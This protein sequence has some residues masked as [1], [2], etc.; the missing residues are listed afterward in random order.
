MDGFLKKVKSWL[1]RVKHT[2]IL[3]SMAEDLVT[4][5]DLLTD[6]RK[7]IYR[8]LPKGVFLAAAMGLGYA[9]FPIDLILDIIPFAGYL[10]D[11]AILM[12]LLDFFIARD[13]L[14]YRNWKTG[15]QSRGLYALRE[16]CTGDLLTLIGENRLAAA[17]LTE[18]RQVR[19]LLSQP[20]D[21]RKPLPC[22]SL[23]TGIPQE[24]LTA[25][26]ADSWEAVG[27]FY[28][29]IFRDSRIPWSHLG[30]RPFMPEY[31]SQAST[32][33]FLMQ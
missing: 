27:Q 11:A 10:D 7:G 29:E 22:T 20:G 8:D 6:Y 31:D 1:D 26:G 30:P 5:M 15:L 14:R 12:L 9:L 32:D 13:I 19:L 3:G 17:F 4:L 25:L 24:Q 2:P 28:T 33:D 21:R 23:V 16:Q 18:K